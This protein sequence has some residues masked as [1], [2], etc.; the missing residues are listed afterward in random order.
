M[1]TGAELEAE[2]PTAAQ[3]PAWAQPT[4]V[5][6]PMPAGDVSLVHVVP[7]SAVRRMKPDVPASLPPTATQEVADAHDMELRLAAAGGGDRGT[8]VVPP[9]VVA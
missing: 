3:S 8:H 4:P 6:A 1:M 7:A 2:Y 5:R 9:S